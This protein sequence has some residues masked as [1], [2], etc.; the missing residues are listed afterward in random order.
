MSN[1]GETAGRGQWGPPYLLYLGGAADELAM[2]TARGLAYW[3]PDWCIGQCRQPNPRLTLGL[4]QME[5]AIAK[6]NG[7]DTM[8]IGTANAGGVMARETIADII[9]A[10]D[11]GLN[12][13]SGLHEKLRENAD[14]VDAAARN[15]RVLFDAREYT[16]K[17]PVGTGL[18]RSGRRLLT[19]GTDCSVGKMYTTLAIERSMHKR[20]LAAD[21]RAT[22]QTGIFIA[23]SGICVDAVISD[24]ISGAA[25]LL[26]PA[27]DDG[28]WDLIEGQ[29]SLFHPSYAG[30]SLGL[31]HGS[32]PDALVLC[33]EPTRTHMRALPGSPVPD[34]ERCLDANLTAARLT[35]PDVKAVGVAL[36]TSNIPE[37]KA[38]AAC[39]EISDRLGLPCQ[40]PVAMGVE[41][42]VD[43]LLSCFAR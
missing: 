28:G 40:D 7:A 42:I 32:Q 31:L 29:G 16:H 22:G 27:R 10:L 25:E 2:K 39:R 19:V 17:I 8:V 38:L 34:L 4:P 15:G 24:F 13:V 33:H 5:P 21:F 3:R 35:N 9:T 11:V 12:V 6:A 1:H 30:V 26:S 43:N 20:K 36:N 37:Q 23:G 14:I 41:S 18:K